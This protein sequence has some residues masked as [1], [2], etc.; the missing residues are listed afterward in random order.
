MPVPPGGT[1]SLVTHFVKCADG[2][3]YEHLVYN[4]PAFYICFDDDDPPEI[5]ILHSS[6]RKP[7]EACL[8]IGFPVAQVYNP[9]YCSSDFNGKMRISRRYFLRTRK[10]VPYP[11]PRPGIDTWDSVL[12]RMPVRECV[13]HGVW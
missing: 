6:K 5:V 13:I 7:G 8:S 12:D 4:D 2:K 9:T 3:Y 11:T 1:V 10:G